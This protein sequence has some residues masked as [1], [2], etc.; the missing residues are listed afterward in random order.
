MQ[1]AYLCLGPDD[2]VHEGL[3]QARLWAAELGPSRRGPQGRV[4]QEHQP[5][6]GCPACGHKYM[7]WLNA[8]DFV[9][10]LEAAK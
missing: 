4:L 9:K 2:G 8:R 5:P 10:G 3:E 7:V 1:A 6:T